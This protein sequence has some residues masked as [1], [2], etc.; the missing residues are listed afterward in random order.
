MVESRLAAVSAI[1]TL[2][3]LFQPVRGDSNSQVLVRT[4]HLRTYDDKDDMDKADHVDP[5]AA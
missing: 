4:V 3:A 1:A 5:H 2:H